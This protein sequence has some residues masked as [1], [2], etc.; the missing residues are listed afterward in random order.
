LLSNQADVL[1]EA[2]EEFRYAWRDVKYFGADVV[3]ALRY[4]SDTTKLDALTDFIEG[5]VRTL[6]GRGDVEIYLENEMEELFEQAEVEQ[7]DFLNTLSVLAEVYVAVFVA[8]PIFAIIILIVMGFVGA[9]AIL[10]TIRVVVYAVLPLTALGYLVFLDTVMKS[11]LSG[12]GEHRHLETTDIYDQSIEEIPLYKP[13]TPSGQEEMR[14]QLRRY[15]RR[16]ELYHII[17]TPLELLRRQPIYALYLGIIVGLG[18]IGA[19]LGLALVFPGVPLL[20]SF[21]LTVAQ[22]FT[23]LAAIDSTLVEGLIL[24]LTIY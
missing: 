20:P 22:P 14:R 17:R 15:I 11:P 2:A 16:Q 13:D 12:A 10:R 19:K 8:L 1:G 4:V 3:S 7:E 5:Y 18:Y 6:T 21:S 24:I 9:S 23:I